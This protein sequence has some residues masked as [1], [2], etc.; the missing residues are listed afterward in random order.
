M[1]VAWLASISWEF[2]FGGGCKTPHSLAFE[3]CL[4]K[5]RVIILCCGGHLVTKKL[6]L[7]YVAKLQDACS[8]AFCVVRRQHHGNGGE[9]IMTITKK[10]KVK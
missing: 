1:T 10:T 8:S 6:R 3:V 4:L 5:L 9:K 2:F 7:G